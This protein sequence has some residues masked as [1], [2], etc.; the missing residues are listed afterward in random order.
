MAITVYDYTYLIPKMLGTSVSWYASIPSAKVNPGTATY[1][2]DGGDP[3]S[4]SWTSDPYWT[5]GHQLLFSTPNLEPGPH[6][7]VVTYL[8]SEGTCYAVSL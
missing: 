3:T 6:D 1:S 4:F 8:G 2:I 7:M 5:L